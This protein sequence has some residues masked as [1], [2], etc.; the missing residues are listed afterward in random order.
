[1]KRIMQFRFYGPENPNNYPKWNK[2]TE[3]ESWSFNLLSKFGNVSHLGIQGEPGV[4][5][6]LNE[7]HNP[8]SIGTTGIYELDLEGIGK[9]TKLYFDWNKLKSFYPEDNNLESRR[10][11][12]DIVYDSAEV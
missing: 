8:I 9:I 6:Y 12:V 3:Y 10:L 7:G 11:I 4:V 5:F 1:M 2:Q